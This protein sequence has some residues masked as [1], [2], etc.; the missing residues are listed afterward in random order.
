MAFAPY[1]VALFLQL[2][3]SKSARPCCLAYASIA[4]VLVDLVLFLLH[5]E[6]FQTESIASS[7]MERWRRKL[8]EMPYTPIG[9]CHCPSIVHGESGCCIDIAT[10]GRLVLDT[11]AAVKLCFLFSHQII[12]SFA[13]LLFPIVRTDGSV[14]PLDGYH[15]IIESITILASI[16][17]R[18][19]HWH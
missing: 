4:V 9:I 13:L 10:V 17:L 1:C 8:A 19:R 3:G 12:T 2:L 5:T 7:E 16:S 18:L 11:T 15:S 14:E 6:L